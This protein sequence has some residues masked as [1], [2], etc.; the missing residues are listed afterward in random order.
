MQYT[1]AIAVVVSGPERTDTYQLSDLLLS[2]DW[3]FIYNTIHPF[4]S[5]ILPNRVLKA[6]WGHDTK[7][8][9]NGRN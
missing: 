9:E 8:D 1:W 2:L 3:L 4:I 5:Q 7:S 6:D